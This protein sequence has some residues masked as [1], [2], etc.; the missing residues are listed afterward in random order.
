MVSYVYDRPVSFQV[1]LVSVAS[2]SGDGVLVLYQDR[3]GSVSRQDGNSI[4][5][6]RKINRQAIK[7]HDWMFYMW[8]EPR[9][10]YRVGLGR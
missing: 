9:I 1:R 2:L 8:V 5:Q 3:M 6:D 4:G 7:I 10:G